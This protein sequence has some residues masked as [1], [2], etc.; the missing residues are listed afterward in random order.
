MKRKNQAPDQLEFSFSSWNQVYRLLIELG[1]AIKKSGFEPDVIVGVS[2]GGW[3]PA[4]ILSD[5]LDNPQL[6]NVS[7]EFYVGIGETRNE[8]VLTQPVSFPVKDKK[9]LVVDDIADTG[10]SLKL[11][12]T[13]LRE[14]GASEVRTATVYYKPWS[15]TVPDYYMK[16]TKRWIVFPWE[17]KESIQKIV[18][19]LRKG[20]RTVE[21]IKDKLISSGLNRELAEHF[22]KETQSE[23]S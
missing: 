7:V 4:R 1:D 18:E 11:V 13:H 20:G 8:P 17:R 23:G 15:I 5:L 22:I 12:N 21:H 19:K 14:Q 2:R 10:K 3:V 9:V 6:V 16:E